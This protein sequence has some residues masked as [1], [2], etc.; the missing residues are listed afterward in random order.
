MDG[1]HIQK[2]NAIWCE[3]EPLSR[4]YFLSKK[5]LFLFRMK[6][7]ISSKKAIKIIRAKDSTSRQRRGNEFFYV[8]PVPMIG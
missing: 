2:R 8:N 5:N 1:P 3:A 7:N 4:K 6:K